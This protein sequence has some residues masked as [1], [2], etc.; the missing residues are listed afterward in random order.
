MQS[1]KSSYFCMK[2]HAS[3]QVLIYIVHCELLMEFLQGDNGIF[4]DKKKQS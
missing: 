3:G 1:D 4:I 2:K